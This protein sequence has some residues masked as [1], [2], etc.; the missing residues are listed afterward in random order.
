MGEMGVKLPGGHQWAP[1][2]AV[3]RRFFDRS[4]HVL[5]RA[6]AMRE[7]IR[8]CIAQGAF[9][10]DLTDAPRKLI[11]A[12]ETLVGALVLDHRQNPPPEGSE[13][14]DRYR[15]ELFALKRAAEAAVD[16]APPPETVYQITPDQAARHG[17]PP[18]GMRFDTQGYSVL[19]LAPPGET[20][21]LSVASPGE[22]VSPM[23]LP[24]GNMIMSVAV[25]PESSHVPGALERAVQYRGALELEATSRFELALLGQS[26]AC[27]AVAEGR[28]PR[29]ATI[30][31]DP[32]CSLRIVLGWSGM[33]RHEGVSCEGFS[34]HSGIRRVVETLTIW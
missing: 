28:S 13:G 2:E 1:D 10:L 16:A 4:T 30:V 34:R 12:L 20:T 27:C 19:T 29:F 3:V 32:R 24:G 26:R 7:P 5:E 8:R 22:Y 18:I 21:G 11:G 31:D 14:L 15:A 25:S 9:M 17:L 6:P 33:Q 23:I